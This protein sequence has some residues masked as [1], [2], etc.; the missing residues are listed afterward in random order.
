[1]IKDTLNLN[2]YMYRLLES[3]CFNIEELELIQSL[4]GVK[5]IIDFT[6]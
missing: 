5:S 3:M 2:D 4:Y 6:K 1:M